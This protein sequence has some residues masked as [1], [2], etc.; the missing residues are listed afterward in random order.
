VTNNILTLTVPDAYTA[1]DSSNNP[2]KNASVVGATVSSGTVT[3][4]A[5][6]LTIRYYL[7]GSN[8]IREVTRAGVVASTPIATDV[9]D[10]TVNDTDLTTSVTCTITFAPHYRTGTAT[11][12]TSGTKIYSQTFLRNPAARN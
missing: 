6:P 4:G 9:A 12:A 10:F 2:T 3:Y 1:Y 5:S 11:D 8:Y 7:L